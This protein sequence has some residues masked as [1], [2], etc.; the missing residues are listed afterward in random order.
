VKEIQDE[1]NKFRW[2]SLFFRKNNCKCQKRLNRVLLLSRC[3]HFLS[4]L[5]AQECHVC[6]SDQ[7]KSSDER[8][9]QAAIDI[10]SER[11]VKSWS[12]P[13]EYDE[14]SEIRT[15]SARSVT[16]GSATNLISNP[17]VFDTP[18][19]LDVFSDSSVFFSDDA[20]TVFAEKGRCTSWDVIA[21]H[22][23]EQKMLKNSLYA[24]FNKVHF[25]PTF[26]LFT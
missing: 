21:S 2:E 13:S 3:S 12:S 23:R 7:R 6:K 24:L 22:F 10:P 20:S 19:A 11:G 25:H 9:A 17:S 18:R 8:L 1:Y 16:R 26:Y 4:Q 5:I 14:T 15:P